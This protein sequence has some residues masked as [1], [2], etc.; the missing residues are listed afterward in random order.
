MD[1][2]I[3]AIGGV[4]GVSGVAPT[5][6]VPSLDQ[7]APAEQPGGMSFG[8]ALGSAVDGVDQLQATSKGLSLAAVTGDLEDLHSATIASS[9]S[10]VALETITTFRNRGVE[11]FN[12]IMRMQA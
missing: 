9:Q 5:A 10:A 7:T 3:S 6:Y 2:P 8:A 11:A 12:E 4:N 1:F